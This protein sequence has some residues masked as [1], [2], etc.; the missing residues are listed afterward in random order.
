M[1]AEFKNSVSMHLHVEFLIMDVVLEH[2]ERTL[3]EIVHNQVLYVQTGRQYALA[4]P[5]Y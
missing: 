4:N 2:P 5:F 1:N 3:A